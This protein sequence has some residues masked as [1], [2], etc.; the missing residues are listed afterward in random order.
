MA[1]KH[2][3]KMVAVLGAGKFGTAVANLVALNASRVFLYTHKAERVAQI[4]HS[5][6]APLAANVLVTND[7]EMI[8]RTCLVIFPV[9]P[10]AKFRGLVQQMA[11]GLT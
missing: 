8:L 11:P 3:Y 5:A 4:S 9:V 2:L 7:L 10:A 1:S 6:D